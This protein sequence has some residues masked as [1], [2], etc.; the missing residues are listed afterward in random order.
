MPTLTLQPDEAHATCRDSFIG[1]SGYTNTNFGDFEY[2]YLGAQTLGKGSQALLRVLMRFDLTALIGTA[3]TGATLTLTQVAGIMT[4]SETFTIHRMM[5]PNWTELGVNWAT[6]NGTN[7]WTTA[8]G[9]FVLT[10][11]QSLTIPSLQNLVFDG[12]QPVVEDAVRLRGGILDLLIKGTLTSGLQFLEL[13]SSSH[14][15]P[16]VRPKLVVNYTN[17]VWCVETG[18]EP[19]Y[20]V[21]TWDE[22]C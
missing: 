21:D 4:A 9:D 3:I 20:A 14:A 13:A 17:P 8:G 2:F 12:L 22:A 6:Y 16:E 19:V 7:P 10:P 18:D 5:Q 15:T 1:N 11:I